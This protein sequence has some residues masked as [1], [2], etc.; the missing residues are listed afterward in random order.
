MRNKMISKEDH[1]YEAYPRPSLN[2]DINRNCCCFEKPQTLVSFVDAMKNHPMFGGHPVR[3]K[4]MFLFDDEQ[5]EKQFYYRTVMINWLYTPGVTYKELTEET[6]DLWLEYLDHDGVDGYGDKDPSESWST[7]R[8]Q[9]Q[10]ALSHLT[11]EAMKNQKV[12]FIVETQLL[13]RPY[14]LGRQKMHLLYKVCRAENPTQLS[15]DFLV[16]DNPETRSFQNVQTDALKK[17]ESFLA[18]T[19][20]VNAT[21]SDLGGATQLW[22]AA[23]QGHILA[24]RAILQH[25]ET[26]P[27]LPRKETT[28]LCVAAYYGHV[29]VVREI[30]RHPAVHVNIG[31]I[32]SGRSPLFVA[33]QEGREN[34]VRELIGVVGIDVNQTTTEGVTAIRA[35]CD[36]GHE[37]IVGILQAASGIKIKHPLVNGSS[38]VSTTQQRGPT[39]IGEGSA[40][41]NQVREAAENRA[42]FEDA[43]NELDESQILVRRVT[44]L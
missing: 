37:H 39:S 44:N 26:D 33:A 3:I 17:I 11:S 32:R 23:E 24:V 21:F 10:Q 27:N 28:P 7:W 13:L 14:L 1:Y 35:A 8:A 6:M 42:S 15:R 18:E 34:V 29:G 20:N 36:K 41:S 40:E 25:P 38:S 4:N 31:Q 2:I 5:A 30:L 43:P 12:Q 16:I 22:K 9:I 19:T